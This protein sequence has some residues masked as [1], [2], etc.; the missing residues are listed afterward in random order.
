[1]PLTLTFGGL[2]VTVSFAACFPLLFI[3]FNLDSVAKFWVSTKKYMLGL[4]K[5]HRS[6]IA[7]KLIVPVLV[8]AI[9]AAIITA[10]YTAPLENGIKAGIIAS[11]VIIVV[12]ILLGRGLYILVKQARAELRAS[13]ASTY[14]K[15]ATYD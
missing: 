13:N 1:M 14:N 9:T 3:A 7:H 12:L 4:W 10:I 6:A 11:L 15:G 2:T 8:L 5:N